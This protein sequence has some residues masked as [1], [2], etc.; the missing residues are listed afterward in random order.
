M[1]H[2]PHSKEEGGK[3][4]LQHLRL[5]RPPVQLSASRQFPELGYG[6]Y[7]RSGTVTLCLAAVRSVA[8]SAQLGLGLTGTDANPCQSTPIQRQ[9][10]ILKSHATPSTI[11]SIGQ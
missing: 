10:D 11:L 4:L 6:R 9:S 5:D 2:D 1:Q 8:S 3:K 7:Y